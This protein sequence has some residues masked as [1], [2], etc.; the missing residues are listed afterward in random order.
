MYVYIIIFIY[1]Y[2]YIYIYISSIYLSQDTS[3]CHWG[4]FTRL[5]P[6]YMVYSCGMY[7]EDHPSGFSPSK[8]V[9]ELGPLRR[10]V[11]HTKSHTLR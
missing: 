1:I 11:K 2:V 4:L 5:K 9:T 3:I 8:D 6:V 7:W 10:T